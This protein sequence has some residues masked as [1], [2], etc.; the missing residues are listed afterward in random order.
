MLR[1]ALWGEI[2][3]NNNNNNKDVSK[4]AELLKYFNSAEDVIYIARFNV[5]RRDSEG[6]IIGHLCQIKI[7]GH[8]SA[9]D[10]PDQFSELCISDLL[11]LDPSEVC[12]SFPPN[13]SKNNS[14]DVVYELYA[15]TWITLRVW[16]CK[17]EME[18]G[19][20][21]ATRFRKDE[22]SRNGMRC[23]LD[24]M[25]VSNEREA[26]NYTGFITYNI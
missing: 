10:R 26:T 8:N 11:E 7:P 5:R 6:T 9:Y 4:S 2:I 20:V 13:D 23:G 15:V 18:L 17:M 1:L 25:A 14:E 19:E 16:T 21:K 12:K 3:N 22:Q 24:G